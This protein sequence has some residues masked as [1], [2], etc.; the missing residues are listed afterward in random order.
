MAG[1][2]GRWKNYALEL[3]RG[4]RGK[5]QAQAH[6]SMALRP[7]HKKVCA[8]LRKECQRYV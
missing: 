5:R 4:L 6:L 1:S 7:E 3:L 2:R 8:F